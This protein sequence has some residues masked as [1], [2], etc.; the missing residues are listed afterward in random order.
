[1]EDE[2]DEELLPEG[3]GAQ[4]ADDG[5]AR[6]GTSRGETVGR[7]SGRRVI[8]L[9][10]DEEVS[11]EEEEAFPP[12][13][14]TVGLS[15]AGIASSSAAAGSARGASWQEDEDEGLGM[16]CEV[17]G[18]EADDSTVLCC[19]GPGCKVNVAMRTCPP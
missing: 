7:S 16:V 12:S 19:C 15:R 17:C 10:E 2:E 3:I 8:A 9:D 14:G 13:R 5:D 11:G 6:G 1:M 4:Q 18:H